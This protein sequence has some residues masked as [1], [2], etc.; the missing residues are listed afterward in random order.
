MPIADRRKRKDPR[1]D[2]TIQPMLL[3]D[4]AVVVI[5]T[6]FCKPLYIKNIQRFETM[7]EM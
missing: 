1:R 2:K 5:Q 3:A 4:I 6:T 7:I